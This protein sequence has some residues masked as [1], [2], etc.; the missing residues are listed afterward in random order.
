[1]FRDIS[2]YQYLS[3]SLGH[4]VS[5]KQWQNTIKCRTVKRAQSSKIQ[6]DADSRAVRSALCSTGEQTRDRQIVHLGPTQTSL[7]RS[8]LHDINE[9]HDS[10]KDL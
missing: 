10:L 7:L 9:K 2:T 1:M 4:S 3:I 5:D 6:T 8:I